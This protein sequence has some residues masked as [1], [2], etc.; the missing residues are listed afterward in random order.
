[1]AIDRNPEW[2]KTETG[3][4]RRGAIKKLRRKILLRDA[5]LPAGR[6]FLA[7]NRLGAYDTFNFRSKYIGHAYDNYHGDKTAIKTFQS[8][9][10][11]YGLIDENGYPIIPLKKSLSAEM[12]PLYSA[13]DPNFAPTGLG[14][15]GSNRKATSLT[16]EERITGH[17]SQWMQRQRALQPIM[18]SKNQDAPVLANEIARMAFDDFAAAYNIKIKEL[19]IQLQVLVV[20]ISKME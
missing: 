18:N 16:F 3:P 15:H 8:E 11:L 1:M 20:K 10:Q 17:M 5:Q 9:I 6:S 13:A 4:V 7:T 14:E 12:A 19:E 2:V